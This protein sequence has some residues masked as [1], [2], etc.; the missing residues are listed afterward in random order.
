MVCVEKDGR[1]GEGSLAQSAMKTLL[2][3]GLWTPPRAAYVHMPF[4]RRRCFYCDFPIQVV[5][6]KPGA[7]DVPA[8]KYCA[9]LRREIAM[10]PTNSMAPLRSLYFG[11]GTPSLTPPHLLMEVIQ[12]IR[13]RYGLAKDCEVTLEM[14]PGT[15]DAARLADFLDAG[16]TRVSVG[17]QSFDGVLLEK[18][19]RAH[20]ADATE[21]ALELLRTAHASPTSPLRSFSIDLIGGLPHQTLES[22]QRSLDAAAACGA[23]HVSV[24]DLQVEAGTAYSKW[25]EAGV[26]PLP[27]E[28]DAAAM[29]R[30][31]SRTLQAAG[32]E[33]YEVSN[34]A[35]A[36][37]RSQHNQ[38][39]WRNDAFLGFGLGAT[40]HLAS[41]RLARPRKMAEY[42]A[43][44]DELEAGGF[45]AAQSAHALEEV[46][47]DALTTR[48]MLALRTREGLG[49][50]ELAATFG[51]R[52][53]RAAATAWR[54][55]AQELPAEWLAHRPTDGQGQA[56]AAHGGGARF[57]LSD[58]EGLLFSNEA[59]STVFAKL[60]EQLEDIEGR[61]Q[62]TGGGDHESRS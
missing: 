60:E 20:D 51:P 12:A 48:L 61:E 26:Q 11:G 38:A 25:Y 9:L 44:V 7:A 4:C 43:F 10:T 47:E 2:S 29:Y 45:A 15:F 37:H 19:G 55:A 42:G 21:A 53:A 50:A 34:Y 49:E 22:W 31:A 54:E 23:H 46:G 8:E 36:G 33:H 35:R 56:D 18:A 41:A 30:A 6:S 17:V 57:A 40:S 13:D 24:Y 32:F 58:P 14:D 27:S 16:V 1:G 59:I 52:L 28:E 3:S 5:G 39:Y 62:A